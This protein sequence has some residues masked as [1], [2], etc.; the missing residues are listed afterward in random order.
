MTML[1][2]I[3]IAATTIFTGCNK[4]KADVTGVSVCPT[5]VMVTVGNNTILTELI[6]YSPVTELPDFS[7]TWTSDKPNIASVDHLGI[8]TAHSA[9]EAIITCKTTDGGYTASATIIVNPK[10][11]D[12]DFATLVP[13]FY[14][15]NTKINGETVDIDKLITVKYRSRN[16]IMY[17]IDETFKLSRIGGVA[18]TL[19]ADII[20]DITADGSYTYNA[21]GKANLTMGGVTYQESL[22]LDGTFSTSDLDLIISFK[23]LP[24]IEDVTLNFKAWG[25][26]KVDC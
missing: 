13:N 20:A 3:I 15:G 4:Y 23:N 6:T 8:V 17:S 22:H 5:A 26:Y 24:D 14:I 25:T 12:D 7:V 2:A 1:A 9:G 16:V 10:K 18:L 19:K 21:V 11:I